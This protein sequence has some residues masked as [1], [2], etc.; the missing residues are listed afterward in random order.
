MVRRWGDLGW[1][2]AGRY[3]PRTRKILGFALLVAVL[4]TAVN[5]WIE[6]DPWNVSIVA[7]VLFSI[8]ATIGWQAA[9][10]LRWLIF[11]AR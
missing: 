7:S 5:R 3:S 2:N 9:R 6:H 8:F 11:R 4:V 10:G 1:P